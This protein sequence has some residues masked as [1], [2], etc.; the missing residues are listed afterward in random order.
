MIYEDDIEEAIK[1]KGYIHHFDVEN[2]SQL[3]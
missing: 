1:G 2:P 3:L